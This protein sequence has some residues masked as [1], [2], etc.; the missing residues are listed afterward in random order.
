MNDELL[1]RITVEPG[2]MT[3]KPCLRGLRMPVA[4]VLGMMA[5]GRTREEMLA[6]FPFLE[7]ADFDAC[8]AY[9]AWRLQEYEQPLD[10]QA[11]A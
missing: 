7:P 2:K 1:K 9:A 4:T 6:D 10:P 8:L 11:A 5:A 3:G